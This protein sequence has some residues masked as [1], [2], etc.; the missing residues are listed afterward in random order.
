[1]NQPDGLGASDR[2]LGLEM[3]RVTEAAAMAAARRV[4]LGDK[5]A[6]DQAAVDAM[7]G[8]LKA[9]A[10]DGL[11]VI[12]EGEKDHAPMLYNGE[13]IGD[14][15]PPAVDITVDPVEGT[16][17]TA[18]GLPNALLVIALAERGAMFNPGPCM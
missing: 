18:K 7:R 17:L 6:A 8:T 16:T 1:V 9:I 2:N 14:G 10:M 5:E 12:G 11:I 13:P 3:V 15:Q 4:G